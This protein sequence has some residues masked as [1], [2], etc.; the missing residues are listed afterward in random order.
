MKL[1]ID[2]ADVELRL[3]NQLL[4]SNKLAQ[5][6]DIFY[7]EHHV[8]LDEMAPAWNVTMEGSVKNSIELFSSLREQGIDAHYWV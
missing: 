7:F 5:L 4:K 6:V 2:T 8:Y 3:A 1:D